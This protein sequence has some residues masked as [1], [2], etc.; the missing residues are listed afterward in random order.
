MTGQERHPC[1]IYLVSRAIE[2]ITNRAPDSEA[3]LAGHTVQILEFLHG[4][5]EAAGTTFATAKHRQGA[6]VRGIRILYNEVG[7]LTTNLA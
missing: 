4:G 6:N 7:F 2:N 5:E 1:R 3:L